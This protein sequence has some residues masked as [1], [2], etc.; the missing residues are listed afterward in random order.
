MRAWEAIKG[1]GKYTK[2]IASGD[3]ATND[4]AEAR[5]RTCAMCPS[6]KRYKQPGGFRTL[7]CG[8]PLVP[9]P[10]EACGCL[11]G[12]GADVSSPIAVTINGAEYEPAGKLSVASERCPRGAF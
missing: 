9:V 3:I 2:A 12:A 6:L 5:L 7:W 10:K 8:E 1:A 11:I 4:E